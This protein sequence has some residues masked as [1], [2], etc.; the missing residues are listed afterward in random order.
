ME[1][2]DI[3]VLVK[4]YNWLIRAR[5]REHKARGSDSFLSYN[6]TECIERTGELISDVAGKFNIDMPN[7]DKIQRA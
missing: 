4:H 5:K 1:E 3:D 6:L 7:L 2:Q